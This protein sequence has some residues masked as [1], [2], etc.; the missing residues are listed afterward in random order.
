MDM[1]AIAIVAIIAWAI[2]SI[3]KGVKPNRKAQAKQTELQAE[4]EQIKQDMQLMSER[5]AVLEKIV[6]DEKYHLNKKFA[7]L[8][9]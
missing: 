6:T 3:T 7:S 5:L 2:V 8:N 4:Q 9:N 1:T